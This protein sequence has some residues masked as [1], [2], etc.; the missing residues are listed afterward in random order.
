MNDTGN[1]IET[2]FGLIFL[3]IVAA[4]FLAILKNGIVW[5]ADWL[6][7]LIAVLGSI[8]II[9]FIINHQKKSSDSYNEMRYT[10]QDTAYKALKFI[11]SWG[12]LLLIGF[13]IVLLW[14]I[15]YFF[16]PEVNYYTLPVTLVAIW[17]PLGLAWSLV[18]KM[19]KNIEKSFWI[20][21]ISNFMIFIFSS[22]FLEDSVSKLYFPSASYSISI[23]IPL[24]IITLLTVLLSYSITFVLIKKKLIFEE[25]DSNRWNRWS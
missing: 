1:E 9:S 4:I 23:L 6:L 18:W 13:F 24:F 5:F 17:L 11:F 12:M 16:H 2:I 15:T 22:I 21:L 7:W 3:I 19:H 14:I 10:S 25:N 8:F 20:S